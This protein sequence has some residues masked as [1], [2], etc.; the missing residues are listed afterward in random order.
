MTIDH[1]TQQA[2]RNG[3]IQANKILALRK[4]VQER[5]AAALR[6]LETTRRKAAIRRRNTGVLVAEGDSWFDYPFHDILKVLQDDYAY[7]VESVAHHGDIVED[8]AYTGQ[9]EEFTSRL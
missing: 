7:D 2:I 4:E 3:R 8:M 9:L 1:S 6:K 5:R